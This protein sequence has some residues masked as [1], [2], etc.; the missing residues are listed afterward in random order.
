MSKKIIFYFVLIF[1]LFFGSASFFYFQ[2]IFFWDNT[3]FEEKA[4]NIYLN[5]ND[6]FS[7]L[8]LKLE[9][10]LMNID[11]FILAANKKGYTERVKSGKFLIKKGSGNNE[12]INF[13]RS[14][15]LTVN[16]TF[17]NQDKIEDL[18]K[19]ISDQIE[20]DSVQ[21]ISSFLDSVFLS[22]NNL[23]KDDLISMF[24]PNSYE[25]YWNSSANE[26]RNRMLNEYN[27]FW[28]KS[29]L[30]KASDLNL[31]PKEVIILASIVHKE[32]SNVNELPVI[33]G[34]YVNR[35]RK[36]MKL[37]ADP[38]IIYSI[39]RE[40]DNFD[41]LIRRVYNKDLRIK[42]KYNTYAYKG[43]PP[44]PIGMPD[45]ISI[46]AVLNHDKHNYIYFVVDPYNQGSHNFSKTLR[47]HNKKR[48]IY[49][50]WL[51]RNKIYR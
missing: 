29:R 34:V 23:N 21:L 46:D 41:T 14:K 33:A 50:K 7:N 28:N 1:G 42:S 25:F 5:K 16:V 43:L 35:L 20:P 12:I 32:T 45:I 51:R 48:E 19:R 22:K 4:I 24:I 11:H 10:Y 18:A 44:G 37:Q 31:S 9:P 40:S 17:N 13:L 47:E 3:S 2:K 30:S 26:F 36:G 8:I 27:K 49:I 39:K 38:T 6:D 15:S